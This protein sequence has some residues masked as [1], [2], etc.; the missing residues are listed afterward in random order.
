[1]TTTHDT[2]AKLAAKLRTDALFI[3]DG[4]NCAQETRDVIE[5]FTAS[6]EVAAQ[7]LPAAE[8]VGFTFSPMW[9]APLDGSPVMLYLP[10]TADKFAVGIWHD[11]H[12]GGWGD[13][14][15][16][17]YTH[18]PVAFCSLAN[19]ERFTIRPTPQAAQQAAQATAGWV[20]SRD[21]F[22][23][24]RQWFDSVQDTNGGY[25]NKVDYVLAAKLYQHMGMR[26]PSSIAGPAALPQP[27]P[28]SAQAKGD[29]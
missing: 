28:Q 1:M 21:D 15:G 5:W 12:G 3:F 20:P 9:L 18:E 7:A 16:N 13:D 27:Q 14:E 22:D 6:L 2:L 24:C 26:V 11:G 19:L 8:P 29:A 23:L 10:T 17:Y 25:L 4:V